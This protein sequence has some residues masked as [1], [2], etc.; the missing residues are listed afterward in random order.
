MAIKLQNVTKSFGSLTVIDNVSLEAGDDEFLVLLGPS[1]CGKSTILRMIAGLET[2]TSGEIH[3][4]GKRVDELPPSDRDMAF[5]FQSYALYPHM[6]VRRNIAFPL[7]MR[8]FRWWFHIPFIGDYFKRRIENSPEVRE[9]VE[10]TADTLAL[11]KVLDRHPR[12]LSGGQRQRVALGRAMVRQPSA[13]LMDEP[14]SN[15]DAKLRTAMRA[16]ITQLHQRVGGNFV[17]V[18]HDQIEAMTMGTRI[19]LMRDGHLQQYG[20]PRE[21]YEKPANT[22][23]ARFIGTPPMNLIDA[24][25]EGMTV[26]IGNSVLPLPDKTERPGAERPGGGSRMKVW[27][28]LR[29]GALAVVPPGQGKSLPGTVTLVE[30]VGAES[31]IS[32]KLSG[33]HTAHDDDGGLTDEVMV[34]V[35]GYSELRVGE[36]V[37]IDCLLKDFSLFEKDSGLRVGGRAAEDFLAGGRVGT[38]RTAS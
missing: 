4:G 27:L 19:A 8:Q 14:L 2:V 18:T 24:E 22:Y 3:L 23:V 9:L 37:G 6:T 32:V 36:A 1:G 28:G 10:R 11:T 33:V 26:R 12:T 21:I 35:P 16:E 25:V 31:L 38:I 17:Y 7:I 20:T 5:V 29:P 13:F 30:H 34:S 15:L